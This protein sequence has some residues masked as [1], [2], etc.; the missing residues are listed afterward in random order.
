MGDLRHQYR[1][2][3]PQ[4]HEQMNGSAVYALDLRGQ[5]DSGVDGRSEFTPTEV[6]RYSELLVKE[7]SVASNKVVLVGNSFAAAEIILAT[8]TFK[9]HAVIFLG[10]FSKDL[11]TNISD[12]SHLLFSPG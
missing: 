1:L 2:V 10:Q 5:G 4:L 12:L 6:A 11:L 3:S 9:P 8:E 7:K